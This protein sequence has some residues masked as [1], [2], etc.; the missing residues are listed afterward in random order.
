ML[1]SYFLIPCTPRA[2]VLVTQPTYTLYMTTPSPKVLVA[3]S[4]GVDSSVSAALLQEQGYH[5]EGAFII[6]WTAPW[7]P[8]TWREEHR[9]AMRVAAQLNIPFHTIDLSHEYERDVVKYFVT[10]YQA[11]RTPNPDVMC[12]KYV[13]FGAFFDQAMLQGFDYVATGH[14]ARVHASGNQEAGFKNQETNSSASFLRKQEFHTEIPAFGGMTEYPDG[15]KETHYSLQPT[16]HHLLT[17]ID[18]GKD[19]TYFLWTL[20]QQHLAHTLFPVGDLEKS[21][22]RTL[23][24]QYGLPTAT[25]KDSQGVCFLGKIDMKKFLEHYIDRE[26]GKVLDAQGQVVGTHDGAVFYTLGQRHGFTVT[27]H[28]PDTQP[29]YIVAKDISTNTL[30]VAPRKTKTGT[31]QHLTVSAELTNCNWIANVIPTNCHAR[32]R[33]RQ[34]L[35]TVQ[36]DYS[37]DTTATITFATPQPYVPEGQSLVLYNGEECLGGGVI[38]HCTPQ[39]SVHD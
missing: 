36:V 14:Y 33:Y 16:T 35:Q 2:L 32:F 9:D 11:G 3:L 34:P 20:T 5:V 8:C 6:T 28:A 15:I 31:E 30:T 27:A 17:G 22:V 39:T 18:A 26:P 25:K 13:K 38:A 29:H 24:V 7:L 23:A 4:G 1:N 37:T 21:Q 10:E 19:Q 12:N